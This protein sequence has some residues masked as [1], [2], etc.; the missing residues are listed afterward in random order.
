VEGSGSTANT[1]IFAVDG[2]NGRLFEISDDLSDSLFSVNTIA[3]LPVME[4]FADNTVTLGAYNQYDLHITGSKVGINNSTPAYQLHVVGTIAGT[5]LVETSAKK[6]K[7]DIQPITGALDTTG[8]LQGVTFVRIGEQN[9]E[10][11]FIADEVQGVA[12]ELVS[13]DENGAPYGVHYARTVAILT[14]AVKEL[15]EKVNT[16]ELFIKDLL[17]RI[18]KLENR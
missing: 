7:T 14:E 12:P 9:R 13:Y 4:A 5:A 18:E 10:Y 1:T 6:F 2:N 15:H 11:G 17:A 16:Q 8:Q 3:G